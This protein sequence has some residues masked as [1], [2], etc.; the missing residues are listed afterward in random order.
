M[1]S[2]LDER[3]VRKLDVPGLLLFLVGIASGA[4]CI[5]LIAS[6][7]VTPLILAPSAS[8]IALGSMHVTK[9]EARH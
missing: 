3:T 6:D 4:V 2:D 5:A 9:R 1:K 8:A 7:G